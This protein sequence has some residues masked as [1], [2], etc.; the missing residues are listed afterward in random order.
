MVSVETIANLCASSVR[1]CTTKWDFALRDKT[2]KLGLFAD[3]ICD[4]LLEALQVLCNVALI[5]Q[6][7]RDVS[8][9][10]CKR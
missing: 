6:K 2:H 8:K 5:L 9:N 10:L 4:T 1:T 3:S 7:H